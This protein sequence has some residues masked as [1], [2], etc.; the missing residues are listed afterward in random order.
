VYSPIVHTLSNQELLDLGFTREDGEFERCKFVDDY[1]FSAPKGCENAKLYVFG[2][3]FGYT[4]LVHA[5]KVQTF[6]MTDQEIAIMY[7]G[8]EGCFKFKG[9]MS[10]R[11][12][13]L[14]WAGW[15]K[16]DGTIAEEAR[17]QSMQSAVC[18][19]LHFHTGKCNAYLGTLFNA[20]DN[21]RALATAFGLTPHADKA[22][23]YYNL[24]E[25][26][27]EYIESRKMRD[28]NQ[29]VGKRFADNID[30]FLQTFIYITS[31]GRTT[32]TAADEWRRVLS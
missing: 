8:F 23:K 15:I 20:M 22:T 26:S 13:P 9:P 14:I 30:T 31:N 28:E 27:P 6:N 10:L 17:T 25:G 16:K 18:R 21:L 4:H 29:A 1:G 19:L 12:S 32:S 24:T 7:V 11:K 5:R 3:E 2:H